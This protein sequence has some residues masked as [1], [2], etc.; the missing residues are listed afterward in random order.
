MTETLLL[1]RD[2]CRTGLSQRRKGA[3]TRMGHHLDVY[4]TDERGSPVKGAEVEII[5]EG[6]WKG[7]SLRSFTG[8][9]GHA[10]FQTASDYESS[11]KLKIRVRGRYFGPYR[12]GGGAYTVELD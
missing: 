9:D 6:I 11:R 12:I 7:G 10:G 8:R 2:V 1:G 4:V 5:I 3:E